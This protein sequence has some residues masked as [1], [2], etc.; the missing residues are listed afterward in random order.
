MER[1]RYNL[2][3]DRPSKTTRLAVSSTRITGQVR[4]TE[5]SGWYLTVGSPES[6]NPGSKPPTYPAQTIP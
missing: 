6:E 2:G 5:S 3:G 4:P 1:L